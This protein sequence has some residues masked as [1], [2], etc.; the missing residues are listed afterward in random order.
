MARVES[1][2][3][4]EPLVVDRVIVD[5]RE[6]H[7]DAHRDLDLGRVEMRVVDADPD[8]CREGRVSRRAGARRER[9]ERQHDEEAKDHAE[10]VCDR[11][12]RTMAPSAASAMPMSATVSA[13]GV[14]GV[15]VGLAG[16]SSPAATRDG[17]VPLAS[18][19]RSYVSWPADASI[20]TLVSQPDCG[21]RSR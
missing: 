5:Q 21:M 19:A 20:A 2:V 15:D 1:L 8:L 16:A 14:A 12:R 10:T 18:T 7:R 9:G 6:G 4:D 17:L 11:R 3:A 13:L